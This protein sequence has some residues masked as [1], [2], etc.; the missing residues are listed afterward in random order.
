MKNRIAIF[1]L[2]MSSTLIFSAC[3]DDGDE[4]ECVQDEI[5]ECSADYTTCCTNDA[6]TY[7][8]EGVVYTDEDDVIAAIAEDCSNI[9]VIIESIRSSAALAR[10]NSL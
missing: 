6:C 3:G 8:Y 1:A 10:A 5:V 2:I 4:E 7:E 9:S